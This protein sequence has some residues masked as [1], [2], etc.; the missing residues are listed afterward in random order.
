M[1]DLSDVGRRLPTATARGAARPYLRLLVAG[2]RR[3][4]SYLAAAFGGLAANVTFGFLKAAILV[5]TVRAAGGSL[6]GYDTGRMLAFVWIGQGMLGLVNVYGRDVLG[7]RIRDG[8]VVIDFLR[9]LNLQLAGLAT[10][11]GERSFSLL[12]RGIPT[13]LVGLTVTGM[14]LSSSPWSYVLGGVAVVLG[15]TVSYLCVYAL[16]IL[17]LWLVETRG[18]QV[19]YM[20]LAG[21]FSGLYVPI[22]IFPDWL[23]AVALATPFPSMLM[24]PIDLLSGRLEGAS[25]LLALAVQV[26]WILAIGALGATLTRAGRRHLEVQGG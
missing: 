9:P 14:A 5:A 15:M 20:A 4:S 18:L 7:D 8:D 22:A 23:H 16:N 17:G 1:D 2:F 26:W 13:F 6:A 12:P 10:Y 11:L 19:L 25:A 21:F 24:T 3:Q